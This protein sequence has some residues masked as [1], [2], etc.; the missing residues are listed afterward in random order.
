MSDSSARSPVDSVALVGPGRAGTA[1]ALA[2]A[3]RGVRTTAV[4]GRAADAPS[5]R[6]VALR[7]DAPAVTVPEAGRSADLIVVATPDGAIETA[8]AALAASLE[9]GA[10]VV[11]LAGARGLD[12]LA[13]ISA[14]R[15]DV[16]VGALHPLQTLPS[17]DAGAA[18]LAG[19]WAAIA[20]PPRV[21]ALARF[22]DLRPFGVAD[23]DRAAYHAAAC[24]AANHLVALLSQVERIAAAAH[25]PLEAFEPLVS[26][27]VDNVFAF[28][29]SSALTGPVARGD[30]DTVA[31]HLDSLAPDDR[32]A[33]LALAD[34]ARRLA[35]IDDSALRA[36]LASEPGGG[37]FA[38]R[39]RRSRSLRRRPM[40]P[41][42]GGFADRRRRSRSLRRR[43]MEAQPA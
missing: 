32:D 2:L 27:T 3:S 5:T 28:G 9:P 8:A 34:T 10:L 29:P 26:A 15:T 36:L 35:G 11:H 24:V 40:E 31:R 22:L 23:A 20:G 33:Y 25:V 16:L 37:G 1:L 13:P 4:A 14:T 43:P 39:R 42:G 19:A 21:E 30:T 12:A 41:G 7:L 17:A 6:E 18:R 38:D